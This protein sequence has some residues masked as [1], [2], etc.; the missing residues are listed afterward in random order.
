MTD[1]GGFI[2]VPNDK[3]E[4]Q[5]QNSA[6]NSKAKREA[7]RK[8]REARELMEKAGESSRSRRKKT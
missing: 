4:E 5:M 6:D 1:S 7:A 3:E 8:E 2:K